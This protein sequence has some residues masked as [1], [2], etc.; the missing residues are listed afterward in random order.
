RWSGEPSSCSSLIPYPWL[1]LADNLARSIAVS[2]VHARRARRGHGAPEAP[3]HGA[4]RGVLLDAVDRGRSR[5]ADRLRQRL[6]P[7]AGP[8]VG[9]PAGAGDPAGPRRGASPHRAPA[10]G[11]EPAPR[12]EEHTSELQSRVE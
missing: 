1:A 10:A 8:S 4:V 12:S 11:R 5:P 6:E 9:P 7:A 2:V 3:Q